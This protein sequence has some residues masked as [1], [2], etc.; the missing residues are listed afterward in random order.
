MARRKNVKRIDPRYFLNETVNRNDDGSRLE[1]IFGFSKK[2]KLEK[3]WDPEHGGS[4]GDLAQNWMVRQLEKADIAGDVNP[5]KIIKKA[6]EIW[7]AN[8]PAHKGDGWTDL[9]TAAV[10]AAIEPEIERVTAWRDELAADR[11]AYDDARAAEQAAKAAKRA[12]DDA[13]L[14]A[15]WEKI[16]KQQD[17]EDRR[18]TGSWTD[19]FDF[20]HQ[21]EEGEM[22]SEAEGPKQALSR[23]AQMFPDAAS[24]LETAGAT[25]SDILQALG[26]D[27]YDPEMGLDTRG[28]VERPAQ[29]RSA[30]Q[31]S[32]GRP[33]G[34]PHKF[35]E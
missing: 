2:E 20:S 33:P 19:V 28:E 4:G 12:A 21:L 11:K 30:D 27:T 23:W 34:F 3:L 25:L 14:D 24:A 16:R 15:K 18:G 17:A 5:K 31:T 35:E 1:E 6:R 7:L 26:K 8:D 10:E 22:I 13:A 29:P 32:Q 9:V